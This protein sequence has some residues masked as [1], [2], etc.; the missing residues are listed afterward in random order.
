MACG[1]LCGGRIISVGNL[2]GFVSLARTQNQPSWRKEA[3][4]A[5]AM[6]PS[7]PSHRDERRMKYETSM[8]ERHRF[9]SIKTGEL[10]ARRR[11][12]RSN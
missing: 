7:S 5:A 6:V 8:D 9:G 11:I 3:A 10:R 12:H 4:A 2:R 1:G